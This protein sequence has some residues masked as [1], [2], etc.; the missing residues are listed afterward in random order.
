MTIDN[1]LSEFRQGIAELYGSRLKNVLLYGSW[2]RG[3]ATEDSDID[4][5]VILEEPVV[6]GQEIDRM[7]DVIT[8]TNLKYGVLI[9]VYP[10]ST[11][12]FATVNSPLLINARREGIAA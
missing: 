7:I 4:L 5:M 10:V 1:I 11:K 2:A 12:A 8:D 6:P 3:T 9:S